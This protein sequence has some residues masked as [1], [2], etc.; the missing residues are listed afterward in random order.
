MLTVIARFLFAITAIL[1]GAVAGAPAAH[2][3]TDYPTRATNGSNPSSSRT[4][5]GPTRSPAPRQ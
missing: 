2:A 3:A 1:F 5:Q 4:G